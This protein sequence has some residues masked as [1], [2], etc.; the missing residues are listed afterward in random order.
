MNESPYASP[1]EQGSGVPEAWRFAGKVAL[2]VLCVILS[3]VVCVL[4]LWL[5]TQPYTSRSL[6]L[7]IAVLNLAYMFIWIFE[8]KRAVREYWAESA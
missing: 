8:V 4:H 6:C 7:F 5:S 2:P 3:T 1:A